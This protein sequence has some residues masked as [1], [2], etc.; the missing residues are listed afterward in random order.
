M[1]LDAYFSRIGYAGAR[2]AS[3]DTLRGIVLAHS[4]SIPFENLDILLGR[5]I[6]LDDEAVE[7]KLVRDRRGGYCFEQN[8]LL[9][10][11]LTAL[12]FAAAPLSARVRFQQPREVVTPRTHLFLRVVIDGV[13][14]MADVGL[15]GLT[16]TAPIRLDLMD[17][18]QLTPHET[19]RILLEP[20]HPSPVYFHQVDSAEAW[21]DATEFT[22]EEMPVIDRELGN[23]FTST[24]PS[25]KFRLNLTAALARP[26]GTRFALLNREFTHRRGGHVL[27]R[28]EIAD[29]EQLLTVLEER[30]GLLFP[31]GT[32]FATP[33]LVW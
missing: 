21:A 28:F 4:C 5:G 26:D 25:S 20:A 30:F 17:A 12:G 14:W 9:L 18:E 24:H 19:R 23:W 11:A 3:L 33:G 2:T 8:S 29:P 7:R 10:R 27:E 22:L 32:R 31:P 16:P 13:P 15:G 6:S 1:N